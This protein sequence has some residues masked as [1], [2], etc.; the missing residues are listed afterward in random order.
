MLLAGANDKGSRAL[1][2]SL[3]AVRKNRNESLVMLMTASGICARFRAVRVS[4]NGRRV[5]DQSSAT[6]TPIGAAFGNP[7]A[8]IVVRMTSETSPGTKP[9][10]LSNEDIEGIRIPPS[11]VNRRRARIRLFLFSLAA[12]SRKTRVPT[13]SQAGRGQHKAG[14][15]A[16]DPAAVGTE[17]LGKDSSVASA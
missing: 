2:S 8:A 1:T 14:I 9:R 16:M 15:Q 5:S 7:S 10:P 17:R 6:Q 12:N 13:G 4:R 11:D 3:K